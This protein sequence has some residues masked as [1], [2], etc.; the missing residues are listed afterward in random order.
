MGVGN[1]TFERSTLIS[2]RA[3]G[4]WVESFLIGTREAQAAWLT[5]KM[6]LSVCTVTVRLVCSAVMGHLLE[7]LPIIVCPLERL[8]STPF[9]E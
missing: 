2:L 9:M 5:C 4:R 7:L 1:Q 6:L 8:G 3:P